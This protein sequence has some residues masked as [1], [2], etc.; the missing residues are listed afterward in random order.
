MKVKKGIKPQP[1]RYM[2]YADTCVS[3]EIRDEQIIH[4]D[5]QIII[6]DEQIIDTSLDKERKK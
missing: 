6:R 5:E 1:I 2:C 4:R 3:H